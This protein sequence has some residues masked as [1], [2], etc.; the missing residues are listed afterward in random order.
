MIEIIITSSVLILCILLI[1]KFFMNRISAVLQYSLW[2]LVLVRLIFPFSFPGSP[3]SVMNAVPK[4]SQNSTNANAPFIQAPI[5]PTKPSN[6]QYSQSLIQEDYIP[7]ISNETQE[8]KTNGINP[9]SLIFIIWF[10]VFIIILAQIIINNIMFARKVRREAVL[11]DNIDCSLP[12][13]MMR[14]LPSPCL[15]GV[16]KPMIIVSPVAVDQDLLKYVLAHELC[17]YKYKDNWMSLLRSLC[18]A[19]YWFNPLVWVAAHASKIDCEMACDERVIK[20]FSDKERINYG[21]TLLSLIQGK[22]DNLL[23]LS[24]AAAGNDMKRRITLIAKRR[25]TVVIAVLL[26]LILIVSI[27]AVTFTGAQIKA[28]ASQADNATSVV[29]M[30]EEDPQNTLRDSGFDASA[31]IPADETSSEKSLMDYFVLGVGTSYDFLVEAVGNNFIG[32][33]DKPVTSSSNG[34]TMTLSHYIIVAE[35]AR[36]VFKIDGLPDGNIKPSE[37]AG[38][39]QAINKLVLRDKTGKK[40]YDS[41]QGKTEPSLGLVDDIYKTSEGIYLEIVLDH[42]DNDSGMIFNLRIPDTLS[43]EIGGISGAENGQWSFEIPVDEMFTSIQPL[44]YEATDPEYCD[45]VG[46]YVDSLYSSAYATRMELIVDSNKN[47]VEQP[48]GDL[49]FVL[50]EDPDTHFYKK[51]YEQKLFV[52]VNGEQLFETAE[53]FHN[54]E[55]CDTMTKYNGEWYWRTQTDKGTKYFLYLPTLYFANAE[56]VNVRILDEN[57]KPIEIKLHRTKNQTDTYQSHILNIE[58]DTFE[59]YGGWDN[60]QRTDSSEVISSEQESTSPYI[61]AT[62][63]EDDASRNFETCLNDYADHGV[64]FDM[65]KNAWMYKGKQIGFLYDQVFVFVD[66]PFDIRDGDI[67]DIKAASDRVFLSVAYK[68]VGLIDSLNENISKELVRRIIDDHM[69]TEIISRD[70]DYSLPYGE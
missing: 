12:V 48:T 11:L 6:S 52:E 28:N 59:P 15:F 24:T 2:F 13:Y 34:V 54:G 67:A 51:P 57:R 40:I 55:R 46:V 27:G 23:S 20:R 56:D 66:L 18:C 62:T 43:I 45:E 31:A 44:F 8:D 22:K 29:G 63:P 14:D 58:E 60:N 69:Y 30:A 21:A 35:H 61:I 49:G 50:F 65:E 70:I 32:I 39:G 25:K 19:V 47:S 1:R 3:V 16:I 4:Y 9:I 36:F 64:T 42:P 38:M 17:H 33:P 26:C 53:E 37:H 7:P 68:R 5:M 10:S 41:E